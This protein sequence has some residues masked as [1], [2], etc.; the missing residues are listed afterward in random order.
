MA[1]PDSIDNERLLELFF[2]QSLD[3]FFFM[4]LDEAVEWSDSVDKERV[5]DY[6][7]EHQRMT[8]LNSAILTQFNASSPEELLGMTPAQFFAHDIPMAKARWRFCAASTK[9]RSK[10]IWP[11]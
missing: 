8:K 6:V 7:F 4:M 1:I 11:T 10:R 2:S 5:L 3:G 9:P